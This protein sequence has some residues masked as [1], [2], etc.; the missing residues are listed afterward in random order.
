MGSG[1]A[2]LPSLVLVSRLLTALIGVTAVYVLVR[3]GHFFSNSRVVALLAALF[4]AISPGNVVH[5]KFVVGDEML[6]L[7]VCLAL[8][9]ALQIYQ[10]ARVTDYLL[11][12][13]TVGFALST[14]LTGAI[15]LVPLSIAHVWRYRFA[16]FRH[17]KL[18]LAMAVGS[19]AFAL[20]T[21]FILVAPAKVVHDWQF[22]SIH[23]A[24]GHAGMEGDTLRWYANYLW[25]VEGPVILLGVTGLLL[26]FL[27]KRTHTLI[28]GSLLLCYSAIVGGMLVRN[29]RT[30]LPILPVL[31]VFAAFGVR[32]GW[33]I[34]SSWPRPLP[35]ALVQ[36][37]I[38]MVTAVAIGL[39]LLRTIEK[40]IILGQPDGRAIAQ[41]QLAD[42]L[43]TGAK[44]AVEAYS[45][46]VDPAFYEVVGVYRIIDHP[47]AWYVE[48]GFDF[49]VLSEGMYGR[50]FG[51]PQRYPNEIQSYQQI[52]DTFDLVQH[53]KDFGY[54]ITF[55]DQGYDVRI[56]Q[57]SVPP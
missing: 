35:R 18:Y 4:L 1:R 46:Y 2:P 50:F 5:S 39:P 15:V 51:D 53:V 9:L 24:S 48:Q 40:N 19:I 32:K 8:L 49:V 14:K 29:D 54:S 11:A 28:L 30:I 42:H 44:V 23:Y 47:V 41:A 7:F 13:V 57:V 56:Y 43:P 31:F 36:I 17:A 22:E 3:A 16:S 20:T 27:R 25:T 33:C 38:L 52:F 21:P 55:L 10:R 6:V 37:G 34:A 12:G 45:P 26:G